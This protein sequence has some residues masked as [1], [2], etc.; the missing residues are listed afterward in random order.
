MDFVK[1][2]VVKVGTSTLTYEN[3]KLNIGRID[4]LARTIA[5]IKNRGIEVVLVSSG[6]IGVGV[7]KLGLKERPTLTREKQAAAAVGQCELMYLYDKMFSEYG[8]KTGQVLL[9]RDVIDNPERK[10]NV[11]NTFNTLLDMHVVP[12]VNEN[13]AISIDEIV[14]G[15]ND[16]L[17]AVVATITDADLLIILTDIDGLFDKDP[18]INTDAKR[19][20]VVEKI[21]D[22]VKQIAGGAGSSRGT[23]G[24]YTKVL[25]A[26][27]ALKHGINTVV[28][29]G[30]NPT[31]LYD[32]I[33][34]KDIGTL[35]K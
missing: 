19:I 17:S 10:E 6:A 33:D 23:G 13:D 16:T 4:K 7:G 24:M 9:T 12:V 20:S 31:I 25:A 35:F 8:Y 27:R 28:C 1:R 34:G 21:T 30:E 32:I 18:R 5:D 15:D 26:E 14:I 11:T 2:M 22:E 29:N 3:G